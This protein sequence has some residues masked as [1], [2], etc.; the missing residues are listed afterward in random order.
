[1]KH[2]FIFFITVNLL[3]LS[4][5]SRDEAEKCVLGSTEFN[6]LEIDPYDSLLGGI[7]SFQMKA[8]YAKDSLLLQTEATRFE[9]RKIIE[10]DTLRKIYPRLV[11]K[12][13]NQFWIPSEKQTLLDEL[14]KLKT[15]IE[16]IQ[17]LEFNK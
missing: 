5:H 17:A 15:L 1:M 13:Q 10:L 9:Y 16:E 6:P 7:R 3:V 4:I 2:I 11:A 12:I 14:K 8:E